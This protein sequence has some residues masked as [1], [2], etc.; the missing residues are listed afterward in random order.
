VSDR[1]EIVSLLKEIRDNQVSAL[2]RQ[3]E[4]LELARQQIERSRA[5]VEQSIALQKAAVNRF[6]LASRI[7]LPGIALC[8]G[9]IV[10]L[11]VKYF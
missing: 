10:Y 8:L 1:E 4:H 11:L 3:E 7:A 2:R 6:K 5:Q 9:L